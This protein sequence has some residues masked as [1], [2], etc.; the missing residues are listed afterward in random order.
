MIGGG[1]YIEYQNL[2]DYCK[3][4]AIQL[5]GC[6]PFA[7]YPRRPE[8]NYSSSKL[9]RKP[10]FSPQYKNAKTASKKIVYGCTDLV[11]ADQFLKQITRLGQ[12]D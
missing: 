6:P 10:S 12:Q 8:S 2:M 4:G 11:N 9:T 1:N 5:S 7:N 3:V